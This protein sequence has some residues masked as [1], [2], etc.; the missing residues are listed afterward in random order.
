MD[1]IRKYNLDLNPKKIPND[2]N[3]KVSSSSKVNK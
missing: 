1:D 2:L 3:S